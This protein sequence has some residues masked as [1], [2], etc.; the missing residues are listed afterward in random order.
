MKHASKASSE[1]EFSFFSSILILLLQYPR[2]APHFQIR[3]SL[4]FMAGSWLPGCEGDRGNP[5]SWLGL[6]GYI[7]GAPGLGVGRIPK[8]IFLISL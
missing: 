3:L 8:P 1:K 5:G 4:A 2:K 6:P 7:S